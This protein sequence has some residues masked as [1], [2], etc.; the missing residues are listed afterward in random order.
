MNSRTLVIASFGLLA[1]LGIGIGGA[2]LVMKH[3]RASATSEQSS[4]ERK[5]L[6]WHDPMVPGTKFDK[7]GKSPFMNMDLVPVYA[8]EQDGSSLQIPAAVAQNVGIR[9]GKVERRAFTPTLSAV[10]SVAFDERNIETVQSR[11]GGTIT[12]LFVKAPFEHVAR[13]QPLAEVLSPEWLAAQHEFLALLDTQSSAASDIRAAAR[14]RLLVLG[15]P[16]SAIASIEKNRRA[17]GTTTIYAPR[18]GV[19][20]KL[21]VRE[22]SSFAAG[23][24]LMQINSLASVWVNAE[25]PESQVS[26]VPTGST[27]T[28]NA[29]AWPGESFQ[30]RVIA[31][32]PDLNQQ[33]RTLTAR[34]EVRN[35][36]DKLM[37]GMYVTMKVTTPSGSNQLVVPSESVIMT[38]ERTAVIAVREDG[39]FEVI[40]VRTGSESEGYTT[41][42][43]GLEEGQSIVLSGQFLIDSEASLKATV[44]RLESTATPSTDDHTHHDSAQSEERVP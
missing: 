28:V 20:A 30:G 14:E 44:N 38:G 17:I 27:V 16:E 29:T 33:T 39:R 34:I 3:D 13:G 23:A 37:P 31:L 15:V 35:S 5:V 26:L 25:I 42:L 10:G 18:A 41:V 1:G 24:P 7:P 11:V 32:L 36:A 21:D 6:Y 12:K 22:G 2:Y 4:S 40:E 43:S 9:L 8:D 19:I